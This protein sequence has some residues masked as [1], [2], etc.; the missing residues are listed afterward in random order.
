MFKTLIESRPTRP[1]R[2]GS[3]AMSM[4]VHGVVIAGAVAFTVPRPNAWKADQ[5]VAPI[6]FRTAPPVPTSTPIRPI[7]QSP[8]VPAAPSAP[9][10]IAPIV[11][12]RVL[13]PIDLA[14]PALPVDNVVFGPGITPAAVGPASGAGAG[15]G[16]SGLAGV[17]DVAYVERVPRV[18]GDAPTPRYPSALRSSGMSGRVLVRFVVDTSGRAEMAGVE[19]VEAT[20]A[21]FA[22]AV[23]DV[24]ARYRFAPGEVGGR[25]VRTMVQLPFVFALR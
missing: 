10:L 13:P 17:V 18:L 11:V 19:V 24:L 8:S 3:T 25:K 23:R 9:Q 2:A 7:A 22:D 15:V 20:H 4:M 16:G 12:S 21:L 5:P 1:R 6:I 14:S